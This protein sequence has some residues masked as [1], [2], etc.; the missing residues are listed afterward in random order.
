MVWLVISN[1]WI[2]IGGQRKFMTGNHL[3]ERKCERPSRKWKHDVEEAMNSRGH[4]EGDWADRRI[5]QLR[6]GRR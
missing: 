1:V 3:T 5:W 2:K 6:S 4:E